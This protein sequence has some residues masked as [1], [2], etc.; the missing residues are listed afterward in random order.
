ILTSRNALQYLIGA[1]IPNE[2]IPT[3]A[4]SNITSQ[5]IFNAGLPSEL[6]RYRPDVLQAEYNLKAAGANIEVARASY[7]PSISLASSIG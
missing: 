7:F 3:P 6:L 4:V 2:L 1:P 5:K